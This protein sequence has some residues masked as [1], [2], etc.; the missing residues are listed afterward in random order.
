MTA[1]DEE[2]AMLALSHRD[3]VHHID[4][5]MPAPKLRKFITAM[6]E[7][8]PILERIYI[9][10]LTEEYPSL[11]L[12][13]TFQAPNLRKLNLWYI[14][15]P[16]GS[17]LLTAPMGLVILWLGRISRSAYFSPS[18]ILTR[19]SLMPQLEVLGIGFNSP[20]PGRNVDR[21][22][23]DNPTI[24]HL[25]LPNLRVLVFQGVSAYLEGLLARISAP[26]LSVL[27][28]F[29]YNQLT[30][31]VPRL[32]QFMQTSENFVFSTV[33][34]AFTRD[35]VDLVADPHQE[36][37]KRPFYLRIMC[38]HLDWQVASV[39]QILITLFPVFSVVETLTLSHKEHKW[40]SEW[41]NEVDQTHWRE[42][43]RLLSSVKTLRVQNELAEELS[44]SLHLE[45][46]ETSPQLLPNL[47]EIQHFD[48]CSV[49]DA[50]TS[51]ING[52]QTT[53][54]PVHLAFGCD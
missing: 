40:S 54:Y 50:R 11:I 35:F 5:K 22:L 19:I 16:L 17:P 47:P 49:G 43:L 1:E 18:Y 2:N 36:P 8:F 34:L 33:Q 28:V 42:L 53:G 27:Q 31:T 37:W 26:V 10:C 6:N 45:D 9:D 46:G 24:A 39:M 3:R 20:L 25:T 21:Q 15:L 12:P 4:L 13:Q 44:R 51:F 30:F 38:K 14:A 7:E 52:R 32:L 48:G 23:L 29:F 41:H